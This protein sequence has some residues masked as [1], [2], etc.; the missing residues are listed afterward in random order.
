MTASPPRRLPK[1]SMDIRYQYKHGS[2][3]GHRIIVDGFDSCMR[4]WRIQQS[5][6]NGSAMNLPLELLIKL[7]LRG[8]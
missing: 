7:D 2:T 8:V 5:T 3:A 1:D 4:D 6:G